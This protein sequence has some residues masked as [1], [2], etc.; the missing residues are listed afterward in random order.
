MNV[1]TYRTLPHEVKR[2]VDAIDMESLWMVR[3]YEKAG[4]VRL[5]RGHTYSGKS[6]KR[7]SENDG[8]IAPVS[9]IEKF[10]RII[11][12]EKLFDIGRGNW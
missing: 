2:Q 11:T 4:F 5:P 3:F 12:S 1:Q 10:Q 7:Y 8:M 6:G 9:S